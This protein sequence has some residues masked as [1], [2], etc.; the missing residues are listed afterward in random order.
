MQEKKKK[1]LVELVSSLLCL[2]YYIAVYSLGK[3]HIWHI[4]VIISVDLSLMW[5]PNIALEARRLPCLP[6]KSNKKRL[7]CLSK[8]DD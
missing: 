6:W 2:I 8:S 3:M 4:S 5:V 7:K 1:G